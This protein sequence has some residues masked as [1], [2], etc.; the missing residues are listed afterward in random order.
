MGAGIVTGIG[1][2]AEIVT[3]TRIEIAIIVTG[4]V[5]TT[6]IMTV[7]A[8][9][10]GIAIGIVTTIVTIHGIHIRDSILITV[11][12][13]AADILADTIPIRSR[14]SRAIATGWRREEMTPVITGLMT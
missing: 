6:V 2:V 14:N 13:T 7:I 5:I 1:M 9:A 4:G 3:V 10:T 11:A 12:V 8:D